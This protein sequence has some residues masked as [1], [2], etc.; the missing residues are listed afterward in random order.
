MRRKDAELRLSKE[1]SSGQRLLRNL[2]PKR[3]GSLPKRKCRFKLDEKKWRS[4]TKKGNNSWPPSE[5]HQN[6]PMKGSDSRRRN[7]SP[8]LS[9]ENRSS[10]QRQEGPL[11]RKT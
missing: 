1:K 6:E 5:L 4:V 3:Q 2:Q 8:M 9:E 10:L 7:R 11:K